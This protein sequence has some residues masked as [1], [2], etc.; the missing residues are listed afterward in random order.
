MKRIFFERKKYPFR[1]SHK[2]AA[3]H[4][5]KI[6]VSPAYSRKKKGIFFLLQILLVLQM[7]SGNFAFKIVKSM[8]ECA[9]GRTCLYFMEKTCQFAQRFD[10]DI[11]VSKAFYHLKCSCNFST[12]VRVSSGLIRFA[13]GPW[14]CV[15]NSG[16]PAHLRFMLNERFQAAAREATRFSPAPFEWCRS[17]NGVSKLK[18]QVHR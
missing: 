5:I 9:V 7:F 10:E 3:Y 13:P 8:L 1:F 15:S 18:R 2:R 6:R 11:T 4:C 14:R 16:M 17:R 12:S